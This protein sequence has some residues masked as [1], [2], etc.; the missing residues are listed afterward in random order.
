MGDVARR[1]TAEFAHG[2]PPGARM[3]LRGLELRFGLLFALVKFAFALGV[4]LGSLF[5]GSG[6]WAHD[7]APGSSHL[8]VDDEV[9]CNIS[10]KEI[11][12]RVRALAMGASDQGTKASARLV[13]DPRGIEVIIVVHSRS[14]LLGVRT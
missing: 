5:W 7:T 2:K 1:A 12:V 9:G 14:S 6:A 8:V 11:S 10:Q 13:A 3:A 4:A